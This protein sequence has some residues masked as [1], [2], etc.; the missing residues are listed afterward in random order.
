MSEDTVSLPKWE[1]VPVGVIPDEKGILFAAILD[2]VVQQIFSFGA[3]Q[4][5]LVLEKPEFVMCNSLT[6][7]GM[8]KE[9]ATA[10]IEVPAIT[11]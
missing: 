3:H 9:E 6:K 5:S 8:T 2:G 10:A 4:A 7:V 11:Q 1:K